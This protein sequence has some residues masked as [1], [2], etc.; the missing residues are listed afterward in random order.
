VVADVAELADALPRGAALLHDAAD[1]LEAGGESQASASARRLAGATPR[2]L[3]VPDPAELASLLEAA[4]P[5][6]SWADVDTAARFLT[7]AR[8]LLVRETADGLA[9]LTSVP[10][11]WFGL[12][13][14]VH[15]APTA[16]G[17]L[18]FGIR[19]HGD[20]PALLWD[21]EPH[22]GVEATRIT[23]PG[24]DP[25]WSTTEPTGDALLAPV[26]PPGTKVTLKRR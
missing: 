3:D 8:D 19:W 5:T 16:S 20:R 24:L 1:L 4:S 7:V 26:L 15:Q 6:W 17:T 11:A 14:E 2:Q 25:A 10:E 9:L 13:I 21:L 12:G 23:V 18:S 22:P